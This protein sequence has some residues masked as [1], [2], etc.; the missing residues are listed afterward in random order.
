MVATA[1]PSHGAIVAFLELEAPID[2]RAGC[3][4]D[5]GESAN[6]VSLGR[7]LRSQVEYR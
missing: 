6:G 1:I 2:D 7:G 4:E 3:T 5:E